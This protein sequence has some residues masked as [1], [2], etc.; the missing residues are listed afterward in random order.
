V[1][2]RR[3]TV[4][5][6]TVFF[7]DLLILTVTGFCEVHSAL[8]KSAHAIRVTSY[9]VGKG[10]VCS[11]H[12]KNP[13]SLSA[14]RPRSGLPTLYADLRPRKLMQWKH[15]ELQFFCE[16]LDFRH[17]MYLEEISLLT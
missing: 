11:L 6:R 12:K 2:V 1:F 5:V 8:R 3:R 9:L 17:M 7:E 13:A 15:N 10:L 14:L 16:R 4:F